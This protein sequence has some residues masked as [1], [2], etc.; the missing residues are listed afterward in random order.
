M[1][2]APIFIRVLVLNDPGGGGGGG[3]G[4]GGTEAYRWKLDKMEDSSQR[5]LRLK[6]NYHFVDYKDDRKDGLGKSPSRGAGGVD[7]DAISKLGA[8][9]VLRRVG[10]EDE[11]AEAE[12]AEAEAAAAAEAA[13]AEAAAAAAAAAAAEAEREAAELSRE[14]RRK[15]LLSVPGTLVGAKR[16]VTGRVDISRAAVHFTADRVRWCR[17]TLSNL[18]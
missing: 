5:R 10:E 2:H 7:D 9:G 3:T 13:E 12:A 15:V 1:S 4:G 16:T 17:L 11:A 14:D 8:G 18:R 6:R